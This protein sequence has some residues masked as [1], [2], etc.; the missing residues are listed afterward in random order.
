M[1]SVMEEAVSA[2]DANR[3]F[4]HILRG[5]KTGQTYVVTSHGTPIARIIPATRDHAVASAAKTTLMTRLRSRPVQ[6][7]GHRWSRDE[8]YEG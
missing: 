6:I 7:I 4:S 8:L 5:V 1:V 2:S 3:N